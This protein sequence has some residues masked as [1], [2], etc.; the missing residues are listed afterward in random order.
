[1]RG[2]IS[3]TAYNDRQI[4]MKIIRKNKAVSHQNS[5]VCTAY[6]YQ[7]G[8]PNINIATVEICGRYPESGYVVN[9]ECLEL[10]YVI[11]G[12]AKLEIKDAKTYNLMAGDVIMIEKDE[13]YFWE[14]NCTLCIACA[15]AWHPGQHKKL[16]DLRNL[17]T[18]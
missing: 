6:E 10:T 2:I 3:T 7:I 9:T 4:N 12:S 1:M 13:G 14:G 15:P 18:N 16:E 5:N 17:E 8:N 11:T